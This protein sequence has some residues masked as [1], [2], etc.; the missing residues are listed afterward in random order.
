M[1]NV[2][3]K[4]HKT[5]NRVEK[6]LLRIIAIQRQMEETGA[7]GDYGRTID[8][9]FDKKL[10]NELFVNVCKNGVINNYVYC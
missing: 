10:S 1:K 7:L 3:N 5:M 4:F 2:I 9:G 6:R 8:C